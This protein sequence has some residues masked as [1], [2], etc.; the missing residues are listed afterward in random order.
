RSVGRGYP[1]TPSAFK[2]RPLGK[3]S[4]VSMVE[5]AKDRICDNISEPLELM[6]VAR[7]KMIDAAQR[8]RSGENSSVICDWSPDRTSVSS[9]WIAP[10]VSSDLVCGRYWLCPVL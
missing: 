9:G 10:L 1:P 4:S 7:R 6:A 3:D 2:S 5:P 8:R